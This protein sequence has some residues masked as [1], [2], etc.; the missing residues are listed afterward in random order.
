VR[1][2]AILARFDLSTKLA[3]GEIEDFID[4]ASPSGD[5]VVRRRS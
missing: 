2:D 3:L 5:S 4:A 1:A